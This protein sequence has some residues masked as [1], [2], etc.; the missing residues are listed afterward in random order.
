MVQMKSEDATV[1]PTASDIILPASP[2]KITT[3]QVA[4]LCTAIFLKG[5]L[6]GAYLPFV[7]LWLTKQGYS[8]RD[9]GVVAMI[10]ALSS[11]LLP[12]IGGS[13]DKL[14]AHNIGL[15]ILLFVLMIL[16]LSYLLAAES[17]MAILV[18][19]ALTA[20]LIRASNSILDSLALYA[21]Q[22]KG[23]FGRVRLV[24]D[25]GFGCI[26]FTV[27][28]GIQ[29]FHTTDVVFWIFG[30]VCG[31]LA[32]MWCIVSPYMS[33]IRPDSKAMSLAEFCAQL[34]YLQRQF[35][36]LDIARA[37]T[38]LCLIGAEIGVITTFEFV[39]L[40]QMMGSG[41]LLGMCKLVGTIGA[42]PVWWYASPLMDRIGFKNVQIIALV[43]AAMRLMV[44]GLMQHAWQALFSEALAGV[45]GLALIY[46]CITIFAGRIIDEDMKSTTQTVIFV[47]FVGIGAGGSPLFASFIVE[48]HG[49]QVMFICVSAFLLMVAL[50]L[51]V[52]DLMRLA[53]GK[54][55]PLEDLYKIDQPV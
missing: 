1:T 20:P 43:G 25:V 49:L 34:Q 7:T 35:S 13:L 52:W 55:R 28:A 4:V 5:G 9:L 36:N 16:K 31:F 53:L 50:C 37:L 46:C 15:S 33:S 44:L 27:G 45:G 19:T 10:D 8:P 51:T 42:I 32:L 38:I 22:D 17:F 30:S 14:R 18:L 47:I 23:H 41:L 54:Y 11:F 29:I 39:L 12:T 48:S 6:L 2:S 40:D 24:G 3:G 26:S 21:L